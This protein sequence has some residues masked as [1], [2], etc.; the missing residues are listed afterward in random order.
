MLRGGSCV[1]P[2]SHLRSTYRNFFYGPDRWRFMGIRL[3]E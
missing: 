1:T 3:A 2:A